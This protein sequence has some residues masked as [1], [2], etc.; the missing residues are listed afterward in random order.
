MRRLVTVFLLVAAAYSLAL[1]AEPADS[2]AASQPQ[3]VQPTWIT[4]VY[5]NGQT[6]VTWKDAAEGEAGAR[7]RYSLYRS[8]K[9]IT[10]DNLAQA[11]LCYRGVLNNS[12]KMI[13]SAYFNVSERQVKEEPKKFQNQYLLSRLNPTA[14]SGPAATAIIEEGGRPLPMWSGLAVRTITKPGQ[15]FYAVVTTNERYG[16]LSKVVPGESATTKAVAERVEP[17]QPIKQADKGR[18]NLPTGKKGLPLLIS[19]HGSTSSGPRP[20]AAG[21]LFLYFATAQM[22]W[23]DGLPGVFIVYQGPRGSDGERLVMAPVDA[24]ENPVGSGAIETCWFGYFCVP[25]GAKHREP[26]VYPFTE[27]RL[28]WMV[29]W[30]MDRYHVDPL[31]IYSA[32]QSMGGMAS[33]QFSFRHPEIFAAVY[34]R[35]QRVRQTW[36][37]AVLSTAVSIGEGPDRGTHPGEQIRPTVTSI[38]KGRYAKPTP[39]EDGKTDYFD[40]M[41]SVRWVRE[42][43]GDLPFYAWC[44]GRTDWVEPWKAYIEMVKA[45]TANHH[46]FAMAWTNGGHDSSTAQCMVKVAKYYNFEKFALNQSYPAFGNSSIDDDL[47]SGKLG[48][49]KKLKDGALEGGINLGFLWS[50]M[51]DQPDKWSARLS[52][53]L[54]NAEMTVDVTPRRCQKFKP[55]AGEKFRWTNTA[56]G[57]GEVVADRWGLVTVTKVIIKPGES[58]VLTIGK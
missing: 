2:P 21:E 30:A 19:L 14:A 58:T 43:H 39:M 55:K 20:Q 51:V 37:P 26:R 13:G 54:A 4:A 50:G 1:A 11:E 10:Q 53:D 52:N 28:D 45:L 9:P 29:R 49:D 27:R 35:L 16:P 36:L 12:A 6:F 23:R 57:Q 31:R 22:G 15:S 46:G 33:T 42:Q 34:P 32:G 44:C 47:G 41:D 7:L 3:S 56:A 8:D 24:I 38:S 18:P 48:P 25:L 5:R 17:I 40:H